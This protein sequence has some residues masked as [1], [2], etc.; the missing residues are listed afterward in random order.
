MNITIN[1]VSWLGS[2]WTKYIL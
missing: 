1:L 2:R